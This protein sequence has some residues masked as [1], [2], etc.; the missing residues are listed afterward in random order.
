MNTNPMLSAI[1]LFTSLSTSPLIANAF[2]S[3]NLIRNTEITGNIEF[4]ASSSDD[5][6]GINSNDIALA[7]V[8]LSI[9]S[10]F[11]KKVST[12]FLLL[13]ED[14]SSIVFDEAFVSVRIRKTITL[15]LGRLYLPFGNYE[16]NM[17]SDT[18]A[19]ELSEARDTAIQLE[20]EQ[21]AI[22]ASFYLFDGDVL[23]N[24]T[25]STIDNMGFNV[26]YYTKPFTV[27][28][29]YI[30]NLSDSNL[31]TET[32]S[33]AQS[34]ASYTPGLS[35]Y[36]TSASDNVSVFFEYV[37]ALDSFNTTDLSFESSGAKPTA[38]NIEV[39]YHID[40]SI[41]AAAVQSS[42]E[43]IDLGLP[44]T[45]LL[46]SYTIKT[47]QEKSITNDYSLAF[48]L[49]SDT[50]YSVAEGGT[51]NKASTLTIQLGITF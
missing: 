14:D 30:N 2:D 19:L 28:L 45:R 43:A 13:H 3:E 39:G 7:T 22:K 41:F 9:N 32:I 11:A 36:V 44:K 35:L 29:S 33:P 16:T 40:N 20:Y 10:V 26:A 49:A 50:D 23:E 31:I 12:H 15:T 6:D 51:G 4:E 27:G 1:I 42:T 25:S 24:N 38:T 46:L 47:Q 37:S 34:V 18:L 5:Y 17:I 48:E 8:E 21:D